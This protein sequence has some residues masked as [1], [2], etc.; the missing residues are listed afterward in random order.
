MG[1]ATFRAIFSQTHLVTLPI[2]EKKCLM[3]KRLIL[4]QVAKLKTANLVFK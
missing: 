1:R 4:K 2:K 3:L